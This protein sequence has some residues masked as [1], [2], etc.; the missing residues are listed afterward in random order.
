MTSRPLP[1][2]QDIWGLSD[3]THEAVLRQLQNNYGGVNLVEMDRTFR[4]LPSEMYE[5]PEVEQGTY[6]HALREVD[7]RT[8][9]DRCVDALIQFHWP[10]F[11]DSE[12]DIL[13]AEQEYDFT[14]ANTD[15]DEEEDIQRSMI[16]NDN[17]SVPKSDIDFARLSFREDHLMIELWEVKASEEALQSSNQLQDHVEALNY[18]EDE[19]GLEVRTRCRGLTPEG[20]KDKVKASGDEYGIPRKYDGSVALSSGSEDI[21]DAEKVQSFEEHFLGKDMNEEGEIEEIFL[22]EELLG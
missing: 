19:T 20:V 1:Q 8:W 14:L 5:G 10:T 4:N 3:E 17:I 2:Y 13:L 9:H 6:R 21:L 18:F 12:F 11:D 15:Y 22:Q 16:E 7:G